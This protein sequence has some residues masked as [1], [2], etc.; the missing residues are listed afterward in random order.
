[1]FVHYLIYLLTLKCGNCI[2]LPKVSPLRREN[3]MNRERIDVSNTFYTHE[4]TFRLQT[5]ACIETF[6]VEHMQQQPS[7]ISVLLTNDQN[8]ISTIY[9]RHLQEIRSTY[10][11][12]EDTNFQDNPNNLLEVVLI[13]KNYQDIENSS[14]KLNELCGREC[15]YAILLVDSIQN[16]KLFMK[17]ATKLLQILWLKKTSNVVVIGGV[18]G[19]LIAAQSESFKPNILREPMDPI[20]VGKCQKKKWLNIHDY[21][22][23]MKMNNCSVNIAYFE[24]IPYAHLVMKN[25]ETTLEGIEATII[26]DIANSLNFNPNFSEIEW[27][28]NTTKEDE[29]L[30]EF[31]IHKTIDL[32]FGGI[33]WH[34][35]KDIDFALAYDIIDLDW[36]VPNE[37]RVSMLGL[38]S[39]LSTDV[40]WAI[41][42]V[43]IIAVFLRILIFK[44]MSLLEISAIIIGVAWN[45]Q[46]VKLSYRIKFMSWIIFAFLLTQFY[47]ASM[48]GRLLAG[49]NSEINTIKDLVNSG[50]PLAG[51][52][53]HKQ[54]FFDAQNASDD[55]RESDSV[56][57]EICDK[58]I[59]LDQDDYVKTLQDLIDGVNKSYAL[60]G[61]LNVSSIVTKFDP[62]IVHKVPETLASL[63][64]SFATWRGLPYLTRV[65]E[66]LQQL[67]QGGIVSHI[68]T[69]ISSKHR[70]L[71]AKEQEDAS[72]EQNFLRMNDI[73]PGFYLLLAGCISGML[74]LFGELI[75]F[76]IQ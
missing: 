68:G 3:P 58:F 41:L 47:L 16:E 73:A 6:V 11:L 65:D 20:I 33:I 26:Y 1:M 39:P 35:E 13:I 10:I 25:N 62:L 70:F 4:L 50:K 64:V 30:E 76:K 42:V 71:K 74:L 15:R 61:V 38:V 14:I 46:P 24:Q 59:I 29:V 57:K 34:P 31:D 32:A 69:T 52:K 72:L 8:P 44:K 54:L 12:T 9:L 37:P 21:F 51:T 55:D 28:N 19:S 2:V 48:A 7:R 40:W 22:A 17:E 43:L 60:V 66:K 53:T 27:G 63:P 18:N 75:I 45:K 36:L 23:P 67:V 5:L 56:F 49:S